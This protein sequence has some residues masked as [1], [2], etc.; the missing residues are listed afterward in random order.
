MPVIVIVGGGFAGIAVARRLERLLRPDEAEIVLFSRENYSLFTPMLPEVTSGELEVRHVVTPVRAQL[1]RTRFV[2]A[3]VDEIDVHRREVVYHHVLTGRRVVQPYDQVVLALGSSTST[4]GLPGVAEHTWALKTLDDADALRNQLVWLLEL[5]DTIDD[6]NRPK[7]LLTIVV[8]GGGFTGVETAGEIAELFRSVIRF[9]KRLQPERISVVLIEAGPVLLAGLPA[10]MGEYSRRVLER[11]GIE[12]LTG[13]GV[14]SVD[15]NGIELQSGR[16]IESETVIW[17]AGVKPSPTIA[18]IDLQKTRRGAVETQPDMRAAGIENV[19]ALGDCAAIPDEAGGVYPMTAQ[20]ALREGPRVAEN[21][22]AALR[23][24]PTK[25]FRYRALGMMAALGGRKAVA[26]LPGE[27]VI[28]GFLAWFFWRSYYLLR[29]PGL[30]RKLRV[31]FD[32]TL[33]LL[34][35]RDTAELRFGERQGDAHEETSPRT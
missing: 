33:E 11:R 31:A 10:K 23:G 16:R 12:V 32:W 13:D 9:Y 7:R 19:W 1:R 8:V 24:R 34:F 15:E 3:D 5:A 28:T 2:L 18:K 22:A 14:T 25:P 29:L 17:S 21:V 27:I 6:E 26:Q 35:P 4:F 20:H 30:D